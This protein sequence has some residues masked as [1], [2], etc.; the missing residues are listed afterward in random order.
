MI[1]VEIKL[2]GDRDEIINIEAVNTGEIK[3]R[4]TFLSPPDNPL[5]EPVYTISI[6]S[7]ERLETITEQLSKE[8]QAPRAF[9]RYL[10]A[11]KASLLDSFLE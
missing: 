1:K 3:P 10:L 8:D 6:K 2:S 5:L 9:L 7:G 4:R 11:N